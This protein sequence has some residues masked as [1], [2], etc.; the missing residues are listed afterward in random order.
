MINSDLLVHNKAIL[1]PLAHKLLLTRLINR[2]RAPDRPLQRLRTAC[3]TARPSAAQRRPA[4]AHARLRPRRL[5]ARERVAADRERQRRRAQVLLRAPGRE[6]AL[7]GR[8]GRGVRRRVDPRTRFV[9]LAQRRRRREVEPCAPAPARPRR[10][11]VRVVRGAVRRGRRAERIVRWRRNL[12]LLREDE[13]R[14]R[15]LGQLA[16]PRPSDAER[17]PVSGIDTAHSTRVR[18]R[19]LVPKSRAGRSR[20]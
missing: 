1:I 18:P 12:V 10:A 20:E 9:R 5:V 13:R 4:E 15:A 11:L 17:V 6:H 16:L 2:T 14:D 3:S 19:V 8:R 7:L